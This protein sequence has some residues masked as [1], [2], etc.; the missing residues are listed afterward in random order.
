[1]TPH[2]VLT[3]WRVTVGA[4]LGR[5]ALVL[6]CVAAG[7]A[8]AISAVSLWREV[9]RRRAMTI[10]LLRLLAVA[11]CLLV[12]LQ[13][14]VELGQVS[15]LPNHVAVLVDT[16]RSMGVA[17]PDHGPSRAQ[18]AA[19]IVAE[20][21]PLFSEWERA[22]HRVEIYSF[23]EALAAATP[24]SLRAP[25]LGEA[26]R[27][28]E[29]L[30]ELRGRLAGRD[31]GG[32]ILISD[33][34]DT[35]RI[36]RGPLD[37]E[38]RRTLE[39]LGAP[40]HTVLV[41]ERELRDLSVAAVLTDDFAFVRTPIKLE[42]VLRH[43][44]YSD[45]QVEVTLAREGRLLDAKAVLLRGESGQERVSFDYTPMEPGNF[46]FEIKT[47]VLAG[48]ALESNNSQVFTM[49]VI[50]DRVRVLHVCGRPSWDERF[51]RSILRLDPNVDL[52]SFFILRTDTDEMPLGANEMSLIPFPYQE[53]FD[54]QLRSFDLLIFHNFNYKP[55]WVEPY[56]PGVRDYIQSGGA[57]AMIGGDL[58]FASGQYGESALRDV[59]PVDL[60]GIPSDGPRAFSTDSFKPRLTAAGRN[61][62]VTSLSLDP[63][64][65]EARWAALPPL[66]GI[67]RVA[68]V[69]PNASVLLVHPSQSTS[70]GKPAPVLAV[71][72]AGKGRT[73][74]LLTDSAWNWGFAAGA[75]DDGRARGARS[76]DAAGAKPG[77]DDGRALQR[78]WE[79]AIRWL[80]HDPAL[81]LL[82]IDLDRTEYRRGQA[83]AARVRTLHADYTPAGRVTVTLDLHPA[84]DAGG[85]GGAAT[86][87]VRVLT[88]TTGDDGEAHAELAGLAAGAYRL[89]GRA[90]LDG[91]AVEEQA[92]F[93]LRPEGRELDDVVSREE[94]LR[95]IATVTGG[96]FRAGTLGAPTIRPARQVRVGNLRTVAI[97]SH[98]LLLFLAVA[99][100]ASE[101]MLRRRAGHG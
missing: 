98:P 5:P 57:L 20:A 58:S 65:N 52:V 80:V 16:S 86:N 61:H 26:T 72:D 66:Q 101:W 87:P 96:E 25:P 13:P 56:L 1:V 55:Y 71:S 67:N 9:R 88:V 45:R 32:V 15:I 59:L 17:P 62:P 97:W 74:A 51:L 78:F 48:E 49:K 99:L 44:G 12:A 38:T 54:E 2:F 75:A 19:R 50:R 77:N 63:K 60:T 30:S 40:V 35:G 83:V 23:G 6:V 53:I 69:Q 10:F 84:E 34:I 27:M 21:A 79:G 91:R 47:P 85:P 46:V 42:A 93:V 33:G 68:R 36:A 64:A 43:K 89:L 14:S 100:L 11:T 39:A 28:G 37:G 4:Q 41:G 73:L 76:E 95:Q 18:R 81:T 90:T 29:A 31:V 22:G 94:V 7:L 70:D 24:E 3:D 8:V 92:T 82:H